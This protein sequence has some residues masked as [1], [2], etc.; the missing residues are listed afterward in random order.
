MELAICII[1]VTSISLL[2]YIV[3]DLDSPFHGFFRVDLACMD[4]VIHK[5]DDMATFVT[6]PDYKMKVEEIKIGHYA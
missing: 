6:P 4:D 2:C 1:T 5:L 3:S